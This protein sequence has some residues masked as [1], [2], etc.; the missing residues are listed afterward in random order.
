MTIHTSNTHA[1]LDHLI[2]KFKL[3]NDAAIARTLDVGPPV[4]SK[5]RNRILPVSDGMILRIH[6]RMGVSVPNI[7]ALIA[8]D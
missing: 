2:W 8:K 6:E 7:R 5:I 4:I 1:L 3:K